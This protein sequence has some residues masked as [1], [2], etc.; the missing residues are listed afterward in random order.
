MSRFPT[1]IWLA[2]CVAALT[3]CSA[4]L[5]KRAEIDAATPSVLDSVEA[6][7]RAR[8]A[9]DPDDS[10]LL[11]LLARTRLRR[12]EPV[13]AERLALQAARQLPFDAEVLALLGE[14]YLA[15]G[16]RFR[17]LTALS[18][19][20][21]LDPEQL[22][23]YVNLARTHHLLGQS[24]AALKT[25]KEAIR[26]EPNYYPARYH[27]ARILLETQ[28][29]EAA[30]E[31]VAEARRI[32]PT[33]PETEV[34]QIRVAKA[35][36]R[37]TLAKFL[38]DKALQ[39]RPEDVELMREKLDLHYQ[40]QE[41]DEALGLLKRMDLGGGLAPE[42]ALIMVEIMRARGRKDEAKVLLADVLERAPR[43]VPALVAS[44]RG[45][46]DSNQPAQALAMINQAVEAEPD[47]ADSYFWKA[48]AHFRL[49]QTAQG[50]AALGVATSLDGRHPRVRLLRARR[51]LA[52][53]DP[54]AAARLLA[55]YRKDFPADGDGLLVQSEMLAMR[56]D[57]AAAERSL[58]EIVPGESEAAL[59]F[60]RARLAYLQGQFRGVLEQTERLLN[61]PVAS[62]RVVYLH[63]AA[64]GRLD[65][66]DEAI[67]ALRPL[68]GSAPAGGSLHRLTGDLHLLAGRRAAA[69]NVY[70]EG[71]TSNPRNESLI[72]ALSRMAIEK[73]KWARAR[74]WLEAGIERPGTLKTVFLERLSLVYAKLNEPEK[75]KRFLERYLAATDPLLRERQAPPERGVLFSSAFPAIGYRIRP[76]SANYGE[77]RLPQ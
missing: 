48:L 19:A 8:L 13:E 44:A 21:E 45:L 69:E 64:L 52:M 33:A 9:D 74:D 76:P 63:G 36:G 34:L 50:D 56:G 58:A 42:D 67:Q 26:R 25:L 75:S 15:Q 4:A 14:I 41:W 20:I 5:P 68:L 29:V 66:Y 24:K 35:G 70:V 30:A 2:A 38:A 3:A 47:S 37:L 16:K 27:R 23:A 62:W 46:I 72:E 73:G 49:G 17:A 40:R 22:P 31:A 32:R 61:A 77:G 28:Q 10:D 12:D 6:T 7:L 11:L 53:G 60:A 51:L 57:Y 18:R 54:D 43:F 55:K 59:R 1:A 71:L 39:A 65:K